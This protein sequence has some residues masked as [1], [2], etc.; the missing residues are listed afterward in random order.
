MKIQCVD[1]ANVGWIS[2]VHV[3]FLAYYLQEMVY[4]F[5]AFL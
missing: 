4:A 2:V 5:A 1:Y 3:T